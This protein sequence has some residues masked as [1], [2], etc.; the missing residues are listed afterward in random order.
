[1]ARWLDLGTR[2]MTWE[3]AE[4]KRAR[5]RGGRHVRETAVADLEPRCCRRPAYQELRL[6]FG[7]GDTR[8]PNGMGWGAVM[9]VDDYAAPSGPESVSAVVVDCA[10][11]AAMK[12]W[13]R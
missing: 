2:A 8:E 3:P 9:M 11:F 5:Q 4:Q 10:P 12:E 1:M 13:R 6:P 7:I